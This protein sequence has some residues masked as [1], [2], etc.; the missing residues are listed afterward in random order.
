MDNAQPHDP[1]WTALA[2]LLDDPSPAVHQ[3][4][5]T[6]FAANPAL[7][8]PFLHGLVA[9]ADR[10]LARHAG[11]YL[12]ELKFSDPVAEFRLF[13]RSLNYELETG[14]ILLART[15]SPD[16]DIGACCQALDDIAA[17]CR[18]L[19]VEPSSTR[20]K[21]RV[22]NRVLFHEWG[23]HGNVEHYTDP[24]NSLL[25]HVLARRSGIPIS[26]STIYLL[27]AHR[28]DLDLE[29]VGLPGHFVVGCFNDGA[30][31]FIDAFDGGLFRD[32]EEVFDLLRSRQIEPTLT[33]LAPT[34]IR[35]MLTRACRNLAHHYA[36]ANDEP[37]ARLFASF[38]SEFDSTYE[39]NMQA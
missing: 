34:P 8:A 26:L 28:L 6:E 13:I 33:D 36:A 32:A 20:E 35:E 15:V 11:R 14:A 16:F 21:C 2:G 22:L 30:P 38:V 3:A 29:P 7:A 18:E 5:L 31:F 27:V 19:I 25:D 37:H 39:R 4:L 24:L 10:S 17:R 23:F 1:R 12:E 9:G